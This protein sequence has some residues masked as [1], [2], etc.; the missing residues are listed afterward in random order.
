LLFRRRA[1][2]RR[3][4]G[5]TALVVAR[6]A[7]FA[8]AVT[9]TSFGLMGFFHRYFNRPTRAGRYLADTAFWIYIV[10]QD[11]LNMVVLP[12]VRPWGLPQMVQALAAVAIT[13]A[14]ALVAFELVIR[15]TPL[16]MLFGPPKRKKTP[17]PCVAVVPI[18]TA[19]T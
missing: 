4:A 8:V 10:H 9:F 18:E 2:Y 12:W 17:A 7:L 16:T 6:H 11:L 1:G 3:F 15:P 19:P 13:T 14:I 5:E